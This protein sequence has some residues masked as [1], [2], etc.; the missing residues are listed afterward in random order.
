M[1]WLIIALFFAVAFVCFWIKSTISNANYSI[2]EY[3]DSQQ[4]HDELIEEIK[5]KE[6]RLSEL[7][8]NASE[9]EYQNG[10]KQNHLNNIDNLIQVKQEQYNQMDQAETVIRDKMMQERQHWFD[11]YKQEQERE[12]QQ[13]AEDFI[14]QFKADSAAKLDIGARIAAEIEQLKRTAQSAVEIARHKAETDSL[15]EF[16]KLQLSDEA[17]A[18]IAELREI[19]P[20]L[21]QP[22]VLGK[23]IWKVYY[24]K[25][26]TDLCGRLFLGQPVTGIYKITN[27]KNEMC[28]VGQAVNVQERWRQHIKRAI[29]AETPTQNKLYPAM[30]KEGLENFSFELIE[31]VPDKLKLD[32]REDYWQ[33][34]YKAKEFGYSIK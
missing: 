13:A 4:K 25:P 14:T 6:S 31:E 12:L 30:K 24:E 8:I 23:M 29:G 3:R 21:S 5:K 28:Y 19:M 16:Y 2:Q 26:Y 7:K 1:I 11:E 34:F 27:L 32:E 20:R 15:L 17:L 10:I 9:L 33:A 22:E 18:D